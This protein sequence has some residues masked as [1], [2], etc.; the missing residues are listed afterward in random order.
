MRKYPDIKDI[1]EYGLNNISD[2]E[3]ITMSLKDFL[4]I[5]RVLEEYMRYL[6]NHDHYPDIEAIQNFLGDISSGG[7][8]E[9]AISQVQSVGTNIETTVNKA[10]ASSYALAALQPNFSEGETG[11]GVA[12]GFGHYH[13]KTA[14]AVGAYYRPNR[15]VQFNVGTVVGNGNQGFNGGLSFKV[16]SGSGFKSNTTSTDE[17]IAQLE[18]RIQELEQSK[19]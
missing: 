9:N 17:K 14:T 19:K 15:N 18:K 1:I 16:G 8:L 13:G 4:Y 11:L 10:T 2:K 6:H 5:R 12:V 3:K 7:G